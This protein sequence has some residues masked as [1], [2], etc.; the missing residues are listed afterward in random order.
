MTNCT[1]KRYQQQIHAYELGMLS[2]NQRREFECHLLECDACFE[3]VRGFQKASRLLNRD[4]EVKAVTARV[5]AEEVAEA[6]T[7]DRVRSRVA[8]PLSLSAAAIMV[9]LVLRPWQIEIRPT[10]E[11]VAAGN[12]LLVLNFADPAAREGGDSLAF[13][14]ANLLIADLAQQGVEVVSTMRLYEI[15][16]ALG[17]SDP[18]QLDWSGSREVAARSR[19]NWILLGTLLSPP[20]Q[21]AISVELVE[22]SSGDM[23]AG[24]KIAALEGEGLYD[25]VDR[26]SEQIA[27]RLTPPGDSLPAGSS[28]AQVTSPSLDAYRLYLRGVDEM[29]KLHN[30]EA[31]TNFQ[32]ALELDSGMPMAYYY[33]ARLLD[34]S[35]ILKAQEH[36]D[37]ASR[38]EQSFIKALASAYA[39]KPQEA[40]GELRA[41][42]ERFP[43]S[44]QAWHLLA[45]YV[46][47]QRQTREAIQYFNRALALDSTSKTIYNELAYCYDALGEGDN[48]IQAAR[49]YVELAPD[50]ANP[51]DTQGEMLARYGH[52]GEAIK[53]FERALEIDPAWY[54]SRAYLGYMYTFDGQYERADNV[55]AQLIFQSDPALRYASRMYTVYPLL[56]QGS[57]REAIA[58]LDTLIATYESPVVALAAGPVNYLSR[59]LCATILEEAGKVDGAIA[60]LQGCLKLAAA[61]S[62]PD[63]LEIFGY[64]VRLLEENGNRTEAD[65]LIAEHLKAAAGN[66]RADRTVRYVSALS[67]LGR[68]EY[69]TAAHMLENVSLDRDDFFGHVTLARAYLGAGRLTDAE[70][71]LRR[72]TD[73]YISRRAFH[74]VESVKLHYYL[75]QV[76]E[77]MNRTDEAVEQYQKFV[78]IWSNAQPETSS[79][80]DARRRLE[81]LHRTP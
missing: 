58:E 3:E 36:L 43:D 61:F 10:Q 67:A 49:K 48:A 65:S 73:T 80:A 70:A 19:A 35:L 40:I 53:S 51:Y 52:L 34:R 57:F 21:P 79:L 41:C 42:V 4:D 38:E 47:G 75:G 76:L 60:E 7:K 68:G 23:A 29:E 8:W 16:R 26:L 15:A 45:R 13:V 17:H 74:G 9:L 66:E 2:E 28:L 55:F 5:A 20:P 12:R 22:V 72:L 81:A 33:L 11:A 6:K 30:A 14:V 18:T 59:L 78:A 50:E 1:D 63:S 56:H 27:E 25:V 32:R 24:F 77:R 39:G 71:S 69:D 44:R 62:P 31:I 64:Y 46:N 54:H 37:R